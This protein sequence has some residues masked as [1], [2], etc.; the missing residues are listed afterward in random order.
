MTPAH[1][2]VSGTRAQADG[3]GAALD[4]LLHTQQYNP[5]ARDRCRDALCAMYD[6]LRAENEKLRPGAIE[7][8]DEHMRVVAENQRLNTA[9][10][11]GFDAAHNEIERLR[12]TLARVE[13]A[14]REAMQAV[15]FFHGP[16]A[17]EIYRDHSPEM[18]RW[19]GALTGEDK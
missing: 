6:A 1:P 3:F 18:K 13:S 19:R 17:W 10:V 9:M 11:R 5:V 14:L 4:D 7:K 2:D 8:W 12:A 16:E 15:E